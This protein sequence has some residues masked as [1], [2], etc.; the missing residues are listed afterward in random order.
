MED[1]V[2][3]GRRKP[4]DLLELAGEVE[5]APDFDHK[6]LRVLRGSG[7]APVVHPPDT[8]EVRNETVPQ[9]QGRARTTGTGRNPC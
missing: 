5:F 2:E 3:I 9:P 1:D 6:A 7:G 4:L 8:G